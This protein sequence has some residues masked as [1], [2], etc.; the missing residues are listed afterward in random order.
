M[1]VI[2]CLTS[3]RWFDRQQ[4]DGVVVSLKDKMLTEEELYAVTKNA[5]T[6]E[7]SAQMAEAYIRQWSIRLLEYDEARDRADEEIERLVEDY[8]HS[9]YVHAYEQKLVSRHCPKHWPDTTVQRVY[10]EN[11]ERL[12]LREGIIRGVLLVVPQGAPNINKLQYWLTKLNDANIEKVEKYAYQYAS[13][14]E[15]F[16]NEWRPTNQVLLYLPVETDVFSKQI[17][18]RSQ[19]VVEDSTSVYILQLTD[20]RM[21]GDLMPMEYAQETI[22]EILRNQWQISFLEEYRNDLYK[23]AIRFNKLKRYEKE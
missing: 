7:D 15:Y 20:K 22:N 3:C 19:I 14:Y 16:P 5:T 10:A 9:L 17:S 6:P 21:P 11:E 18:Q 4:T 23:E 2:L 1:L 13:G 12:R 8:R